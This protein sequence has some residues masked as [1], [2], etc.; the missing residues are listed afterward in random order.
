MRLKRFA[1]NLEI[2]IALFIIVGILVWLFIKDKGDA[3]K[4]AAGVGA[5]LASAAPIL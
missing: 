2:K 5:A 3:A 1:E 4:A